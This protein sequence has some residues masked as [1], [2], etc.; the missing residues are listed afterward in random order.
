MSI[1]VLGKG[2]SNDGVVLLLKEEQIEY[3]YRDIDDSFS[4]DYE[5]VIKAPGI[6]PDHPKLQPIIEKKIPILTDIELAMMLRPHFYIGVSGSNG[7]TTMVSLLKEILSLKYNAIACGNI[8]YS[9]CKAVVEHPSAEIFIVELSSFQLEYA[10]I[11]LDISVLLPLHPCHLDHH[12]SFKNYIKSKSNICINQSPSHYFVFPYEDVYIRKF[13]SDCNAVHRTYSFEHP[14]AHLFLKNNRIFCDGRPFLKVKDDLLSRK[15]FC[16]DLLACIEVC[17]I[18]KIPKRT[19]RKGLDSF[20]E[21]KYRFTRM[22]DDI[23]NDAKSTNPYATI[24]AL[25]SLFDCFLI[26]GGYDRKENL[27]CLTEVLPSIKQVFAYGASK[28]KIYEFMKAHQKECQMFTTVDEAFAN[29]L[30]KRKN[31]PILYSPMFAS[32]DQFHNYIERGRHF[33][34]LVNSYLSSKEK[35]L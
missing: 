23:Y 7:K 25:R 19:I 12:G 30:K 28:E 8:G 21:Q 4:T 15:A 20:H 24:E 18:L 10:K 29:A 33:D 22:S 2:V 6:P 3:D 13:V 5:E 32:Y 31:E 27:E 1:L 26:C 14:L 11:D 17:R 35:R 9:V 34:E 16:L